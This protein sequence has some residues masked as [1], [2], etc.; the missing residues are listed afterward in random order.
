[1]SSSA[2]ARRPPRPFAALTALGCALALLAA[3]PGAAREPSSLQVVES[4]WSLALSRPRVHAGTVYA[5]AVNAGQ[6]AHDLALR[7]DAPGAKT[8]RFRSLARSAHA[9]RVLRLAPG[10]YTLWCT[11][12]GHRARGMVATLVVTP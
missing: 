11:L 9:D 2:R 12:P 4:E 3:D 1:M 5:E 7:R 8:V 6:D 10:R